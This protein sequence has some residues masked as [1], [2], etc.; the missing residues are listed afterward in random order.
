[1][2]AVS[3]RSNLDGTPMFV[4][5][6]VCDI[7]GTMSTQ[8]SRPHPYHFTLTIYTSQMMRLQR[9]IRL[10]AEDKRKNQQLVLVSGTIKWSNTDI[11]CVEPPGRFSNRSEGTFT[12][13][14]GLR[15]NSNRF[16]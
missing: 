8:G 14:V 9:H 5:W 16:E 12:A 15:N 11:V 4:E 3:P 6:K 13:D 7:D 2:L 10:Y 1:M